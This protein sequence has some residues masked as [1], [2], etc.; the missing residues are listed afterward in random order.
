M[1]LNRFEKSLRQNRLFIFWDFDQNRIRTHRDQFST[2]FGVWGLHL[3]H[4]DCIQQ[5]SR[6]TNTQKSAKTVWGDQIEWE[7]PARTCLCVITRRT[8]E[9]KIK[10]K[11]LQMSLKRLVLGLSVCKIPFA[12]TWSPPTPPNSQKWVIET[13][14]TTW[15]C[16]R[17]NSVG[18]QN[19]EI[20]IKTVF[21]PTEVNFQPIPA[22]GGSISVAETVSDSCQGSRTL[23]N[24]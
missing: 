8:S 18:I 11:W 23:G 1:S 24:R 14:L 16:Y 13:N 22:C 15:R 6:V 3:R 21:G 19:S 9:A 5:L 2:D 17:V 4:R 20:S 7:D 10:S 12:R